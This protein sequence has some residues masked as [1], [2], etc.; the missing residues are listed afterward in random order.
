MK[1]RTKVC[2]YNS[3]L[4]F[5]F[6]TAFNVK[7]LVEDKIAKTKHGLKENSTR[8]RKGELLPYWVSERDD[9]IQSCLAD[10]CKSCGELFH[11]PSVDI[12]TSHFTQLKK[13]DV[14]MGL[15]S[16][17]VSLTLYSASEML[18]YILLRL[19]LSIVCAAVILMKNRVPTTPGASTAELAVNESQ[20]DVHAQ[21][22]LVGKLRSN[23]SCILVLLRA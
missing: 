4:F 1:A 19:L 13:Y 23:Q 21:A 10:L 16:A 20:F 3:S 6:I 5:K 17:V 14:R 12:R 9:V 22:K 8:V 15:H 11:L 18:V 2:L 7:S